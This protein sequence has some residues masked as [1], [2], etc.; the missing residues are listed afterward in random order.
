MWQDLLDLVAG[1]ECVV[2]AAPGRALCDSCRRALPIDVL[3]RDPAPVPVGLPPAF[4]AGVY[5]GAV[6]QVIL[7]HKERGVRSLAAVLAEPLARAVRAAVVQQAPG[8][9]TVSIVPIP[10]SRRARAERGQDTVAVLTRRCA[11]RLRTAGW[12]VHV[13]PALA[14]VRSRADQAGLGRRA[15][16]LN[17]SGA[18]RARSVPPGPLVVVDDVI[19]TGSTL[20]EACRALSSAGATPLAVATIAATARLQAVA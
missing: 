17:L 11:A 3:R 16:G 10:T 5:D 1:W 14:P 12:D 8:A 9:S 4:S 19:T 18:F 20:A 15:R 7:A 2:C 6:R 13:H